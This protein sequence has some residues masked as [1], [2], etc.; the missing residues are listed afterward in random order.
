MTTQQLL[1]LD[2]TAIALTTTF[3]LRHS[4]FSIAER[5]KRRHHARAG[6]GGGPSPEF[7][8]PA[9]ASTAKE[10]PLQ[11]HKQGVASI[12]AAATGAAEAMNDCGIE[13]DDAE[14]LGTFITGIDGLRS[15]F[16]AWAKAAGV[17]PEQHLDCIRMSMTIS[18]ASTNAW[19][20]FRLASAVKAMASRDVL[21][22]AHGVVQRQEELLRNSN[23]LAH[24]GLQ[25]A[26]D[27]ALA[28]LAAVLP[29]EG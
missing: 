10:E 25:N 17:P 22:A 23:P 4:L 1:W 18:P 7:A 3:L 15:H 21:E 8:P 13:T 24:T 20:L 28:K 2:V 19:F 14:L 27:L 6:S 11:D 5:I 29:K 26:L 9:A 12:L 16:E